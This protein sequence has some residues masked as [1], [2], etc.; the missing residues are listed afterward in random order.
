MCATTAM[1]HTLVCRCGTCAHQGG[2]PC[3]QCQDADG[4]IGPTSCPNLLCSLGLYLQAF[5]LPSQQGVATLQHDFLLFLLRP[6]YLALLL[7]LPLPS[8]NLLTFPWSASHFL[9]CLHGLPLLQLNLFLLTL[10]PVHTEPELILSSVC[11]CAE[12]MGIQG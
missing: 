2:S 3:S 10:I 12:S 5:I 6:G 9:S 11:T 4:I 8:S 7:P 1:L